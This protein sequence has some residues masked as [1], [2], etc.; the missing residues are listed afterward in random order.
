MTISSPAVIS[1]ASLGRRRARL[2]VEKYETMVASGVLTKRD[3]VE[4][5]EGDLVEKMTKYPPH[6][7]TT[8]LCED[9]IERVLPA[10]WH[11]RQEQPVRIPDRDSEPEPD[12][13]VVRGKRADYLEFHPGPNDLGL[14]VEVALSSVE[15]DRAM[16]LTYGGG[17]IPFYWLLNIPDRQVEVYSQPSGSAGPIGYR[18]CEVLRPGELIPLILDGREVARIPVE[19]LFPPVQDDLR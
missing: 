3:R 15:D 6:S 17:R 8:G 5:I 7:V 10:G 12:V 1:L 11:T 16:A 2:S 4:L 18:R 13:S 9:A 14:V 19:E